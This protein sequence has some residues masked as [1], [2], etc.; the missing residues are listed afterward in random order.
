MSSKKAQKGRNLH[1]KANGK[2][3]ATPGLSNSLSGEIYPEAW[4]RKLSEDNKIDG[5]GPVDNRPSTD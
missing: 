3:P 4:C 5:V 2:P 1:E